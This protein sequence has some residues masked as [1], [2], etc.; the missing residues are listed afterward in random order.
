LFLFF[1]KY[2]LKDLV[3]VVRRKIHVACWRKLETCSKIFAEISETKRNI[4]RRRRRRRRR[5]KR[6]QW[7]DNTEVVVKEILC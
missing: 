5:R 7:E 4:W 6:Y 2:S 1:A 3:N